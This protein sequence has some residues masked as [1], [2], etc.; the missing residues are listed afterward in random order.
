MG[1]RFVRGGPAQGELEAING[2]ASSDKLTSS[3]QV[4]MNV[5]LAANAEGGTELRLLFREIIEGDSTRRAGQATAT[6]MRDTP[7]YEVFFR[8]V[9]QQLDGGKKG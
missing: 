5:K 7:Q 6:A 2:L 1:Y 4:S 9:Q 3:R 8:T